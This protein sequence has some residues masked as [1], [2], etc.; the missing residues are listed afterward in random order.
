M[1]VEKVNKNLEAILKA[2]DA[3]ITPKI[4]L[5]KNLQGAQCLFQE[6]PN[7]IKEKHR[8]AKHMKVIKDTKTMW[9][10][11]PKRIDQS[12]KWTPILEPINEDQS[13]KKERQ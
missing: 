9:E 8:L 3:R 11:P 10:G 7:P 6:C 4:V 2:F 13:F 12:P 5:P 1:L